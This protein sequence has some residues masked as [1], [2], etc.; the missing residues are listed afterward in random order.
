ML[1][2]DMTW[3]FLSK[4]SRMCSP[5]AACTASHAAG[6]CD[7]GWACVSAACAKY[8]ACSSPWPCPCPS[9]AGDGVPS[10]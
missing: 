8:G 6:C 7:P 3:G 2:W 5:A 9:R 1:F 4:R 10:R